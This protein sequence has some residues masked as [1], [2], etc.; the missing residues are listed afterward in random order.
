VVPPDAPT[1]LT[2][3][4]WF[5]SIILEWINPT[6]PDLSHIEIWENAVDDR[7]SAVKI[8]DAKGTTYMRYLG[9]FQGRYYWIRA[10]DLSGNISA[11][12]ADAGVYG[13]SDQEDH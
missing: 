4:G 7:A 6:A 9:S 12:N 8:A 5:G 1:G 13:Y 10:V 11:W 3:T 2:A